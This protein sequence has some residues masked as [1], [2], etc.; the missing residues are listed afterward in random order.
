MA[1]VY[2]TN[3]TVIYKIYCL[4]SSFM[5]VYIGSSTNIEQRVISHRYSCYNVNNRKYNYGLY[6]TIRANGGFDNFAI[7]VLEIFPCGNKRELLMREQFHIDNTINTMNS[8]NSYGANSVYTVYTCEH[9]NKQ[10]DRK[11]NLERHSNRKFKCNNRK[12]VVNNDNV[13]PVYTCEHCNKQFDRK[14]NLE[15]HSNRKFK[16]NNRKPVVNNT[17][18][19]VNNDKVKP[20]YT[21]EHCNKQF[22][23]KLNFERHLNRKFNC[24]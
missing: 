12:P 11:L 7:I 6:K 1:I 3:K 5:Y 18:P 10:F 9:C 23:R 16:C 24:V 4:D 21:C 8:N 17:K 19:V 22:D 2:N 14:L 13:K 20:V 15:R